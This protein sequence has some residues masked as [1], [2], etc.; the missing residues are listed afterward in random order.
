LAAIILSKAIAACS[1]GN[2]ST[3]GMAPDNKLNWMASSIF[4]LTQPPIERLPFSR[5]P[6]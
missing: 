3:I 2:V 6:G 5:S 4:P 1:R